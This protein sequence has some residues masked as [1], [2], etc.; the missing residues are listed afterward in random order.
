LEVSI[1]GKAKQNISR[2]QPLHTPQLI[3]EQFV[4]MVKD[5][6]LTEDKLKEKF[7]G[8]LVNF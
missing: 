3:V 8:M 2:G 1:V 7:C 5:Q 6:Q 4:P